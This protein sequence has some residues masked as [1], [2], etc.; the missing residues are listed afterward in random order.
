MENHRSP[1]VPDGVPF[2]E[3]LSDS[4]EE[5]PDP[6][7][8]YHQSMSERL[9]S[10]EAISESQEPGNLAHLERMFPPEPSSPSCSPIP[11]AVEPPIY[12]AEGGAPT[13]P[14]SSR[15][16]LACQMK[17]MKCTVS[18]SNIP[19][20]FA[21]MDKQRQS[22]KPSVPLPTRDPSLPAPTARE[23]HYVYN[24]Q[25]S[26]SFRGCY[27]FYKKVPSDASVVGVLSN[28]GKHWKENFFFELKK[29]GVWEVFW[30]PT[31]HPPILTQ[32]EYSSSLLKMFSVEYDK[33]LCHHLLTLPRLIKSRLIR[34]G[35]RQSHVVG[36]SLGVRS[37]GRMLVA[38]AVHQSEPIRTRP[39][40]KGLL[41]K[42]KSFL[43]NNISG[44]PSASSSSGC[45]SNA[46]GIVS[47]GLWNSMPLGPSPDLSQ[48]GASSGSSPVATIPTQSPAHSG[49]PMCP[50]NLGRVD[51]SVLPPTDEGMLSR[52]WRPKEKTRGVP[53]N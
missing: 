27:Y 31:A 14:K 7:A 45:P 17:G 42:T 22:S 50:T 20:T 35:H 39:S 40:P 51:P 49:S 52:P 5:G 29:D 18:H 25:H 23:V 43:K 33:K 8:Q 12:R 53:G 41:A 13:R 26:S 46:E 28:V 24:F 6:W 21:N 44:W 4:D 34:A 1:Y 47:S 36:E 30:M 48:V 19:C 32:E 10:L 16:A 2:I 11:S 37:L 9:K 38:P 3:L 15:K